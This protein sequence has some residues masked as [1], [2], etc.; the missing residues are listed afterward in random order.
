MPPSTQRRPRTRR[1]GSSPPAD[2]LPD[3]SPSRPRPKRR[4]VVD[5]IDVAVPL[6]PGDTVNA[7]IAT[8]SMPEDNNVVVAKQY[9]NEKNFEQNTQG[10]TAYAKVAGSTWTYYVKDLVIRIGRPPDNRPSTAGS[11]T[12]PPQ[13]V[14]E[15][16][17]IDLG[18]SKL[19]SRNHAKIFYDTKGEHN[20]QIHV[21]GRNGVKVDDESHKKDSKAVLRSGSVIEIGGVQMMFVLP[22][23]PPVINPSI[24]R[25][26]RQHQNQYQVDEEVPLPP[27]NH[28]YDPPPSPTL[29]RSASVNRPAAQP[30]TVEFGLQNGGRAGIPS[31]PAYQR[32]VLME[33]TEDIDYSEDSMKEMKP[34][35]SYAL[36]IAQAILSSEGEQLTLASIYQYIQDKYAFYRHSAMGWQNSIRHNL[37]LNKAFRKIPRRTDEPGKGMKWELLPE[38]RDEYIKKLR[39]PQ[40]AGGARQGSSQPASPAS[41]KS[42]GQG[43]QGIMSMEQRL[44]DVPDLPHPTARDIHRSVTPPPIGSY[45]IRPVEAYTPDR[46]SRLPALRSADKTLSETP[47]NP[48]RNSMAGIRS[49][50][51]SSQAPGSTGHDPT[52]GAPSPSQL[53]VYG[54][55]GPA[56]T[57]VTPAPQRQHPRLAPPSVGQLPS[58]YL[59]TSSPAPFWKFVQFGSTPAKINDYSP[60]K[61]LH[62]SSPPPVP[63]PESGS[64]V[65]ELGSPLKE[66]SGGFYLGGSRNPLGPPMTEK[67]AGDDDDDDIDFPNIDLTRGFEKIGKFHMNGRVQ[68]NA[69]SWA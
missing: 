12:P 16:V 21:I 39:K 4:K 35:Y 69:D 64:R 61:D 42:K 30:V 7:V 13:K 25:R 18:P 8:L 33:S 29:G 6:S 44:G 53:S 10:V 52:S 51:L 36:L 50:M 14:D 60:T 23:K 9:A 22:N 1:V 5:P 3:S 15:T 31:I 58:S 56:A 11:P 2:E 26:A 17:H 34:P 55:D 28:A 59:P 24:M 38:H 19:I 48:H 20:W 46:G 40:K 47:G 37:S 49:D 66:R 45:Q 68:E 27:I 54:E 32:G 63:G 67:Q 41:P 65:R 43:I 62:S 57:A